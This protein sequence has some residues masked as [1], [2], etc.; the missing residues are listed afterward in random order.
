MI[1]VSPSSTRATTT[2]K[3]RYLLKYIVLGQ[4]CTSSEHPLCCKYRHKSK[5]YDYSR[6]MFFPFFAV[7][8]SK[9]CMA[10]TCLQYTTNTAYMKYKYLAYRAELFPGNAGSKKCIFSMLPNLLLT[11]H[12]VI[13]SYPKIK[14][15]Q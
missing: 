4:R 8:V 10:Q 5:G 1:G 3:H 14:K 13:Q 7:Q 2:R 15:W 12:I 9:T 11:I 6:Q